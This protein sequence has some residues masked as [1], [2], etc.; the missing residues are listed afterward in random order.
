MSQNIEDVCKQ[1]KKRR[2]YIEKIYENENSKNIKC[3]SL[4]YE[5]LK[6][7]DS[8]FLYERITGKILGE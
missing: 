5:N 2:K 4:K 7:E 6:E 1:W 3:F 8:R